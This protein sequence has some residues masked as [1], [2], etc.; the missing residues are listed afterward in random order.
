MEYRPG[1][2]FVAVE[3]ASVNG[4]IEKLIGI[5][6]LNEGPVGPVTPGIPISPALPVGPGIP[7]SPA[8]PC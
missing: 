8:L 1:A 5:P 3:F 7:I 4:G 2:D 6:D